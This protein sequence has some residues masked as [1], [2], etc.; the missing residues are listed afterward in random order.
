MVLDWLESGC[1]RKFL[2]WSGKFDSTVLGSSKRKFLLTS[3]L[4]NA[5]GV[6]VADSD[7]P[8]GPV[9]GFLNIPLQW[10]RTKVARRDTREVPQPSAIYYLLE[11]QPPINLSE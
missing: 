11:L 5:A 10:Y 9:A 6:L 4:D 8:V 2:L 1:D 3:N 7:V